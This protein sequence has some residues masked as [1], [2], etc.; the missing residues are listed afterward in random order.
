MTTPAGI[1]TGSFRGHPFPPDVVAQVLNLLIGGAPFAASLTRQPTARSSI[2]WPTASPTGFAWL[3][4]LQPFPVVVMADDAYVV[5]ICKLGGIV[6]LSNESVSD[7]SIN[8]SASIGTVLQDSLSRDLDLGLLNGS[9]PPEP[10]GVIGVAPA[11]SGAG[12][13]NAV[14]AAKGSIGDAG[15]TATALA[16][17]ATDLAAADADTGTAGALTYPAGFATAIGLTPVVVPGLTTPLVYDQSRCYLA[18]RNDATV[19]A[20][21][22]WHFNL[23]AT[24]IRVKARVTAAIPDAPKSIRKLTITATAQA[25]GSS[26]K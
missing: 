10:V 23:D 25:S 15:G 13:L 14:A 7:S 19:E 9:G 12:L 26:K 21:R 20:S 11:A 6:D 5:A 4:E 16:I 24:S 1:T 22:D 3:G 18:V 8:L 2:A 17:N